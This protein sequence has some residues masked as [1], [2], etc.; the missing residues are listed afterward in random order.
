MKF[1]LPGIAKL[2]QSATVNQ[3]NLIRIGIF[4]LVVALGYSTL[5][6]RLFY[7]QLVKSSGYQES[8]EKQTL[9]RVRIPAARGRILS[10]NGTILANTVPTY[11]V[12][13]HLT[14]L[15][16][17]Q[18]SQTIAA[19]QR[20]ADVIALRIGRVNTFSD[21][22]ISYHMNTRPGLPLT[23]F[24]GLN[25]RELAAVLEMPDLPSGI[26]ISAEPA[27]E[28][29]LK[30]TACHLLGWVRKADPSSAE[31][32]RKFT[33]YKPDLI[34]HN[35]GLE[36]AY[37]EA[38]TINGAQYDGLRGESGERLLLVNSRGYTVRELSRTENFSNG[39]DIRLSLDIHAQTLA[40]HLMHLYRG[41][42][43]VMDVAS[44]EL[45]AM[46][47][48][49]GYDLSQCVPILPA[50]VYYGWRVDSDRP[51][52][53]RAANSMDM[54]GSTIKPIVALGIMKKFASNTTVNCTGR[55]SVGIKCTGVHGEVDLVNAIKYSCNTYFIERGMA[56]GLA[57]LQHVFRSAGIGE[58]PPK[59]HYPLPAAAGHLPSPELK[60]R[61][62]K[63]PWTP[64]STGLVSIGQGM[65]D[66][67]PLQVAMYMSAIANNGVG[68]APTLLNAVLAPDGELLARQVRKE[69]LK[70]EASPFE[71][72]EIRKGMYMV[73]N[74][75]G[76]T[77]RRAKNENATVYGKS[78]TAEKGSARL[79]NQRKNTWFAGYA[80]HKNGKTYA[81]C[82]FIENGQAGGYTNAPI[83]AEFFEQWIPGAPPLPPPS[84]QPLSL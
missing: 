19:V 66:L 71:L 68:Y 61:I 44:G 10:S 38:V 22:D 34:G 69:A 28:Y 1:H 62:D 6:F 11:N 77:G 59:D 33:Y 5:L 76:G 9:R 29:P 51:L 25:E 84:E 30:R 31:D 16:K 52:I 54:P 57:T 40:E 75:R 37:D 2:G 55:S 73:V 8:V 23:L 80:N 67:S 21:R 78:G 83:V 4:L 12:E 64:H 36:E 45:V 43:V 13:L 56:T 79:G 27:R 41:A 35:K 74:E 48:N 47:S 14:S 82:V 15:L 50:K 24:S 65:I 70:L 46:V 7:E 53:D 32:R 58:R 42:F 18:R 81:F 39:N 49:P 17:R 20:C 63:T 72:N 3:R 26:E 60:M